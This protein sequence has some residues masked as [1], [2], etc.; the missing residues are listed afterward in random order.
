MRVSELDPENLTRSQINQLLFS[1]EDDGKLG[2]L[3]LTPGS[4]KCVQYRVPVAVELYRRGRAPLLLFSGGRVWDTDPT[5]QPEALLMKERALELGVAEANILTEAESLHT[6]ANV[7][8]SRRVIDQAIGIA[9]V[10]RI[11]LVTTAYHM[12]RLY[13]TMK[14]HLSGTIT[15]SCCAAQDGVTRPDNWWMTE[16]GTKRA[17]EEARKIIAYVR[18]GELMDEDL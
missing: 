13:M 17:T 11:L 10:S 7:I 9:N 16:V 8:E 15:Y 2:D 1:Q 3:I 5:L 14:T 6:K 12:R 18:R 4:N